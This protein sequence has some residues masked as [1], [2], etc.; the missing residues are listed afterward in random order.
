MSKCYILFWQNNRYN[1]FSF[2]DIPKI[3]NPAFTDS[4]SE[5]A[6]FNSSG[7]VG[8]HEQG[9]ALLSPAIRLASI[10]SYIVLKHW[11]W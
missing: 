5:E 6:S 8:D 10:N 4:A 7:G 3:T 1:N 11:I 2:Y 9:G